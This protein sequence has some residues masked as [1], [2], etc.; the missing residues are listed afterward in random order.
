MKLKINCL[1]E[2][3]VV[4]EARIVLLPKRGFREKLAGKY[5]LEV[6]VKEETP[7]LRS[8]QSTATVLLIFNRATLRYPF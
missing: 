6:D 2:P 8:Q 4:A 7:E 3:F 5:N 1:L